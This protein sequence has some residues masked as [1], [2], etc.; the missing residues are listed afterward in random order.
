MR[1]D[2][3]DIEDGSLVRVRI[4]TFPSRNTA[5]T[6]VMEEVLGRADDERAAVDLVVARHK[7]ET[8][9]SEGALSRGAGAVLDEDGRVRRDIGPGPRPDRERFTFTID[10]A[11]GESDFDDAELLVAAPDPIC[12][13]VSVL[14]GSR[15]GGFNRHALR[16]GRARGGR[17][18]AGGV[19]AGGGAYRGR[20]A[21][22]AVGLVD[23][24]GRSQAGDERVPCRSRYPDAA[25]GAVGRSVLAQARRGAAYDDGRSVPG[26]RA[27][28]VAYDLYPALIRSDARLSYE[29]RR[30]WTVVR[31][32][33]ARS[34]DLGDGA[35]AG[36]FRPPRRAV[37]PGEAAGLA[38]EAAGGLDFDRW[39]RGCASM[40][41]GIR[42]Y[43]PRAQDRRDLAHRG[44]HDPC[45]RDGGAP[46]ARC[47][48][49]IR[50]PRP[51]ASPRPTAWP[52]SC[53]FSRNSRGSAASTGIALSRAIRTSSS[54]SSRRARAGRRASSF[55]RS[56]CDR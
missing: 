11:D 25:R 15:N 1:S 9:F 49:P 37:A 14:A 41:E 29:R 21:L 6:G 45:E 53:P 8:A 7:L 34:R 23:R 54:R 32:A 10:P 46:P 52:R 44:G 22:R 12:Q 33:K 3:P 50:L 43:R 35:C 30:S 20:V 55:R 28:L 38:R 42:G 40:T 13:P 51:R 17:A 4:T 19:V 2:R 48:V 16:G 47:A 18:R 31:S 26:R 24:S 5:A 27:R 36:G 39:R 56:C